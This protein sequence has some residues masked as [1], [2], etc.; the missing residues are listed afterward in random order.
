METTNNQSLLK[1]QT[2]YKNTEINPIEYLPDGMAAIVKDLSLKLNWNTDFCILPMLV[3]AAG[4]IGNSRNSSLGGYDVKSI[5]FG[6]TIGRPSTNK[7][8]AFKFAIRP[9]EVKFYED[10][11]EFRKVVEDYHNLPEKDKKDIKEPYMFPN[12]LNDATIEVVVRALQFNPRGCVLQM[13]ELMAL[14]KAFKR[15]QGNNAEQK[16]LS[17][18]NGSGLIDERITRN[19]TCT[20]DETRLSVI[21]TTQPDAYHR[22]FCGAEKNGLEERYLKVYPEVEPIAWNR[23]ATKKIRDEIQRRWCKI[24]FSLLELEKEQIQINGTIDGAGY[25]PFTPNAESILFDWNAFNTE[26]KKKH[27]ELDS[28]LGK[29]DIIIL[30]LALI[31]QLIENPNSKEIDEVNAGRATQ[32]SEYYITHAKKVIN[33]IKYGSKNSAKKTD[34]QIKNLYDLLPDDFDTGKAH[35]LATEVGVSIA[36]VNRYL[37]NP[38]YFES[39][40]HGKWKRKEIK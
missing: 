2:Q 29:M 5:L 4:A 38:N 35:G 8:E 21:G 20:G 9:L 24:I 7:S 14:W 19:M 10:Y 30:R 37:Q 3:T 34:I 1:V 22:Q 6:V 13:D 33:L 36:T 18:F 32:L 27:P 40:G 25:I 15:Q 12:Y 23:E 28:M 39:A 11:S 26:R 31:L 17:L 16:F